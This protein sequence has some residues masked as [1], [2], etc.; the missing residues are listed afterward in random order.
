MELS[1]YL[2][3]L[4]RDLTDAAAVGGPE[5]ARAAELLGGALAPA[6]R[7]VLLDLLTDA[8]ADVTSALGGPTVEVRLRGRDPELVVTAAEQPEPPPATAAGEEEGTARLTLRLPET[9]KARAEHAAA[10]DGVSV[11]TWLVRAVS[12]SLAEPPPSTWSPGPRR[13]TG[14]RRA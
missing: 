10:G 1:P 14:I 8:A 2:E 5:V 4:R 6:L 11:N 7:L 13:I 9:L 3:S 12:R